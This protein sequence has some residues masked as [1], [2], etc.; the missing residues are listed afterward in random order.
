MTDLLTTQQV[1]D[2]LGLTTGRVRQL[3]IE[4]GIG[5]TFGRARLFTPEELTMLTARKTTPGPARTVYLP[6]PHFVRLPD[7]SRHTTE[8]CTG[9]LRGTQV[10]RVGA[11]SDCPVCGASVGWG[12]ADPE[13]WPE[14]IEVQEEYR[15]RY[16]AQGSGG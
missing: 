7:G 12:A 16:E 8:R 3:A 10:G 9:I 1:A 13:R 11:R 15:R 5:R 2:A 6:C 14:S 4:R